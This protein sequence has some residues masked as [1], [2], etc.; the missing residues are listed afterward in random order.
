[1]SIAI[2]TQDGFTYVG[3]WQTI[4]SKPQKVPWIKH[5]PGLYAFAVGDEVVYIGLAKV[6]HRRL[7]NYSRRAFRDLNRAPRAAHSSIATGVAGGIEVKVFAKVM[8]EADGATYCKPKRHLF[9]RC[10]LFGTEH[11][12]SGGSRR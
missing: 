11:T 9:S 8:S 12:S 1:M 5:Q 7:R 6:L 4:D 3:S 10:I 2:L